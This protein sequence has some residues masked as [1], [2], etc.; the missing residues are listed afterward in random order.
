VFDNLASMVAIIWIGV[1]VWTR[2]V[3]T[4][5]GACFHHLIAVGARN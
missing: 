1:F 2:V 4:A 5:W 3:R